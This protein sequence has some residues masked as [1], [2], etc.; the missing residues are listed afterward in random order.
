MSIATQITRLQNIKAAI[1]QAL[2][3]KGVTSASTHDM[4]DFAT[5]IGSIPTGGNYQSK[6]VS[7]STSQQT[8]TPDSGYDALSSVTVNA[9]TVRKLTVTLPSAGSVSFSNIRGTLPL[10][11]YWGLWYIGYRYVSINGGTTA[12]LYSSANDYE[13]VKTK[14]YSSSVT[15]SLIDLFEQAYYKVSLYNSSGIGSTSSRYLLSVE[16]KQTNS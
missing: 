14:E 5:D 12:V 16:F 10:F 11:D 1:R 6:T 9:I 7:P 15:I 4:D 3:N 2:V 13:P 8:V